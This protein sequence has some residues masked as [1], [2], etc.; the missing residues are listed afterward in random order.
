[1]VIIFLLY[2]INYLNLR[3]Y[4]RSFLK[5]KSVSLLAEND[6]FIKFEKL[7]FKNYN[8]KTDIVLLIPNENGI[9]KKV[10]ANIESMSETVNYTEINCRIFSILK[11]NNAI[12]MDINLL[13][14]LKYLSDSDKESVENFA[15]WNDPSLISLVTFGTY[16]DS[17]HQL[18][19]VTTFHMLFI[20]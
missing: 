11:Q 6:L 16:Q 2:H 20:V 19:E 7:N 17:F 8:Q 13:K 12:L 15:K 14:N 18:N 9:V 1:M 4:R 10:Q 3:K 5:N